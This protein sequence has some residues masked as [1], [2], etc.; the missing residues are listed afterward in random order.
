MARVHSLT[1]VAVILA[2]TTAFAQD[3]RALIGVPG[4]VTLSRLEYD[5]LVDLAS[6]PRGG[7]DQAPVAA[8][9]TRADMRVRV[10]TGTARATMRLDGQAFR[11]GIS[12]LTLIGNAVLLDARMDNRALPVVVENGAHVAFITGPST[13]SAT[14]E[15]GS[16]LT[17]TPGRGSFVLPVP[18]AGSATATIDV[19]GEQA[20]VRL[21]SGL[22][23]RRASANGRTTV[24][25]TLTPG[26]QTTVSWSTHEAAPATAAAREVRMLSDVKSIVSIGDAEVRLISLLTAT[27]VAGEPAQIAV[28]IPV[29]YEV[30]SVSGSS[31]DRSEPQPGGVMLYLSDPTLR[32]HQFLISLERAQSGGSFKLDTGFP[33]IRGVQRETGE[34]AIEGAGTL[35]VSSPDAPGLHR[36]DVRELDPALTSVAHD[37]LM[38]AYRYQATNEGPPMLTLAVHRYA[39]APVLAAVAERAVATTLVTA[40]GRALTE[41]ELSLRNRAQ[42]YMKVDLPPGASIVSVEVAGAPAKPVEGADGIRVPIVRPGPAK[43]DVY[44]VSFVY[45]HAGTPFL[46]KGDARMTLPKMDVPI[47][48]V[49]WELFVPE[50]FK[51]DRFDGNLIDASLLSI[52][53]TVAQI[54][55]GIGG[56]YGGGVSGGRYQAARPIAITP[57]FGQIA[58]IVVDAGGAAIQGAQVTI[59]NG[60]YR[61]IVTTDANGNYL[62]SNVPSGAVTITTELTG[63]KPSRRTLQ[64]DQTGQRADSTLV[65]DATTENVEV[66]AAA[67]IVNTQ[68]SSTTTTIRPADRVSEAQKQKNE[69]NEAPSLNIQNLQRRAS[70]VLP[71]RIDVPR[72]GTSHRFVKPL[73][74]DEL[75]EV[76]F[77]YKRR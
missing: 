53:L 37:A 26:S 32:R 19:P 11:Q 73:V 29:G 9:L 36:I 13:F 68:A 70:G 23:L 8:A 69:E 12:R 38:A 58:G 45:L 51:V 48:V 71:V 2:A 66:R 42:R 31:L 64:F 46:K 50:Q 24:D 35:D 63:F 25:V 55:P 57:Q 20:D 61:Q 44:T 67:P 30:A 49:E 34:V 77:R 59:V 17:F 75:T 22:V 72:A 52:P 5:R 3:G 16:P 62:A 14:L 28:A 18:D 43:D 56:G 10:E 33:A 1:L 65:L 40:E 74:V 4:T 7:G 76:T 21:S 6:Q 15:V 47:D 54:G 27:I 60:I 39:D 41:I